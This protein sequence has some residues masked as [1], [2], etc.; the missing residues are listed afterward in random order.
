[1][2]QDLE[3]NLSYS[4]N[5]NHENFIYDENDMDI[6]NS[7]SNNKNVT[8]QSFSEDKISLE[9]NDENIDGCKNINKFV[10]EIDENANNNSAQL[11]NILDVEQNTIQFKKND[12]IDSKEMHLKNNDKHN[13]NDG[14]LNAHNNKRKTIGALSGFEFK[15]PYTPGQN[16]NKI[17]STIIQPSKMKIYK[18]FF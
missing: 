17:Q 8:F 11:K 4:S 18:V 16:N 15:K 7:K 12:L 5:Y 9:T 6:K 10:V 14:D 13:M 1:M 3:P 2:D